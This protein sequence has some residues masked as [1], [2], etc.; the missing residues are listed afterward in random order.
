MDFRIEESAMQSSTTTPIATTAH[1]VN[2]IDRS[3]LTA[4]ID[5]IAED[6]AN[7]MS[8]WSVSS[9]WIGGTRSDHFVEGCRIGGQRIDRPF[10]IRIDEPEELC[11]TNEYPNP[12]EYL[13]SAI[14]ACMMVGYSAVATLMGIRLSMLEIDIAGDIDLR[15]FLGL[16]DSVTRGCEE[17]TQTI[18]ISADA[19]ED[20]LAELHR[21]V[22]ATS[23]NFDHMVRGVRMIPRL[24]V[25]PH[26]Q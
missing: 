20:Q 14:N 3:K 15:G 1:L 10:T 18:R 7:G 21:I 24:E 4:C 23:P 22:L 2:G 26:N 5:S 25:V 11:G 8:T 12:Q 6:A 17:I 19:T 13:M 16:D 9:R